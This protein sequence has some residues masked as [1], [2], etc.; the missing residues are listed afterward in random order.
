MRKLHIDFFAGMGATARW[1]VCLAALAV[2][3]LALSIAIGNRSAS[4]ARDR[5]VCE[6]YRP[7][8]GAVN[9]AN[10]VFHDLT[11]QALDAALARIGT[12]K[13]LPNDKQTIKRLSK[14]V[15]KFIVVAPPNCK[16]IK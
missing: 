16:V 8:T 12:K 2:S 13:E 15:G 6:I 10:Q 9:T 1:V 11:Q 14:F 4:V 7:T 3:C 5:Q